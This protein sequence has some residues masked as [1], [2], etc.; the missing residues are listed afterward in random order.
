MGKKNKL[1]L[2]FHFP[3]DVFIFIKIFLGKKTLRRVLTKSLC[4]EKSIIENIAN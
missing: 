3:R 4:M 2:I 1:K